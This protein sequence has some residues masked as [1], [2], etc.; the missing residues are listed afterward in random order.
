MIETIGIGIS[1][2]RGSGRF[3]SCALAGFALIL[4]SLNGAGASRAEGQIETARIAL[5]KGDTEAAR[6]ELRRLLQMDSESAEA[7]FLLASLLGREGAIDEAAVGYQ[8]TLALEPRHAAARYNLGTI[9]LRRGEPMRAALELEQALAVRPDHP[10]SYNNL[11]KAY[12]MAGLPDL[13]TA[14]Y[15]EALRLD[16][17][18]AVARQNL[19][20]LTEPSRVSDP[21][22]SAEAQPLTRET[23]RKKT[24]EASNT[25]RV[26][27]SADTQPGPGV[28]PVSENPPP[29][30]LATEA[31]T[32]PEIRVLQQMLRELPHVTVE[33][34]GNRL[35]VAGWTSSAGQRKLLDRVLAAQAQVLDLTTEDVGDPHRLIEVDAT[36]FK[37]IGIDS[38]SAGHNFLRRVTVNASLADGA[39]ASFNWLYSA[40]LSYEVNIANVSEQRIALLARPHLTALTGTTA[41]FVAGGDV[42]YR[43]AGNISGDIKPYPFG[44]TL[45]V[46]PT[47]LRT[48]GEDGKPRIRLMA[49]AGRRTLLPIQDVD[50]AEEGSTVFENISVTSEA[51]LGL[52]ETLILTGLNQ[53][54][55]RTRRSGVPGLKSIPIIKYL[56][57]ER[58]TTISDLAIIILLTP[59]D[60]AFWGE[61]NRRATEEFVEKR[62]A[63]IESSRGSDEDRKRFRV[64]YPDWDKLAPNRLASHF[65]LMETSDA[66]RRVSGMDLA[67]EDLELDLLG[68][69]TSKK[70]NRSSGSKQP[71]IR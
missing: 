55:S 28:G 68:P 8:Q 2:R 35:T 27:P 71:G 66:Y 47:L 53:R 45:D 5:S 36:I 46:T 11:G 44:T 52:D 7:H 69:P 61:E 40:A 51:V 59:R 42:V 34:K 49:K 9:L 13:A 3:W 39:M 32:D 17:K 23:S 31:L 25:E 43:V 67:T 6:R 48:T 22:G 30:P 65:F 50:G 1:V 70:R 60:P 62:R 33:R 29:P 37:V 56:F 38:E 57:S 16:P 10:P 18:N 14:S 64:R 26:V 63:F 54:E 20:T 58:T 4:V 19:A 41:T 21:R 12:F 24:Q 15:R